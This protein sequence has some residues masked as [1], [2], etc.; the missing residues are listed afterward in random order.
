VRN[1]EEK[2]VFQLESA[3]ASG[4]SRH[5]GQSPALKQEIPMRNTI[6]IAIM[7]LSLAGV[8]RAQS[9]Q[10]QPPAPGSHPVPLVLTSPSFSDGGVIPDKY[11]NAAPVPVSL[12]LAWTGTPAGTQAFA[13]IMHDLDTMPRKTGP[14]NLHWL[15]F[16][17]PAAA[18]ALPE[19]ISFAAQLPD[20][21]IQLV[22]GGNKSGYLPLGARGVYH[23]YVIE[24]YALDSKLALGSDASRTEATAQILAHTLAHAAYTGRFHLPN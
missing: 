16:N 1:G 6:A 14:D 23:H 7:L 20:G 12:A 8:A 21:T 3:A 11:S 24:F 15:A 17:I 4:L 22:N 18:T 5:C 13:I 9:P 19:G 10:Y 2:S